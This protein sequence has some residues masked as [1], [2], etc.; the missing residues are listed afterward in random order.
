LQLLL[1]RAGEL[2]T[3]EEIQRK[4][5]PDRHVD[6]GHSLDVVVNR[7]RT[8]LGD[9]GPN[10]RY[11]ETVPR[12]GYRFVEQ[13]T[14]RPDAVPATTLRPWKGRLVR[15]G[16]V[17]LLAALLAMLLVRTRYDNFVPS[18]RPGMAPTLPAR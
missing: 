10:P 15:Y 9:K 8:V 6:F 12:R 7:L 18:Q 3:R 5:W 17:A 2:T 16:I 1:E 13:V 4:L 11:I 14:T